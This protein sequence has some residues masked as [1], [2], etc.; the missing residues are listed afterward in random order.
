M[1][2][3][4]VFFFFLLVAGC[5]NQTQKVT[6]RPIVAVNDHTLTAKEFSSRLA[7]RLKN[8]DAL[9]A[10]D[11][12]TI[13]LA[14]EEVIKNFIIQGLT[15]DWARFKKIVVAESEVEASLNAVRSGYPDDLSFRRVLAEENM[16]FS[17]WQE[18]MRY[19]LIEKAVFKS[20]A[21]AVKDPT[22]DEIKNYYEESRERFKRKE[23]IYLRQIVVDELAKAELVKNELKKTDLAVLAKKYSITPESKDGGLVGWIE[24]GTVDFFDPLFNLQ[25]G[26]VSQIF[27]SPFGYHIA[28]V[29]KKS[30]GGFASLEEARARVVVEFKSKKEQALFL[31]W[32]DQQLRSAKVMRDYDL[33][34]AIH[35]D[36][37]N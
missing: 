36:T 16:S 11:P 10:K 25:V 17:D 8:L 13:R 28:K 1:N 9:A 30:P 24:K 19:T 23:R 7:R 12:S 18:Q 31:A 3:S 15:L 37:R 6:L 4:V 14:K 5:T 22:E 33:I 32:F 35:V 29:E 34:N 27:K 2:S 20:I 21:V 26:T